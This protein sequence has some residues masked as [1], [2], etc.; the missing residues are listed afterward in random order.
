MFRKYYNMYYSLVYN[1]T[2]IFAAWDNGS[3]LKVCVVLL[4]LVLYLSVPLGGRG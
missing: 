1:V 2:F 4:V 3:R